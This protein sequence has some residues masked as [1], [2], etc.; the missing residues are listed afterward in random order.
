MNCSQIQE[1]LSAFLDNELLAQTRQQVAGH[2]ETCSDCSGELAGFESLSAM[3]HRLPPHP[4]QK[5]VGDK[6]K[7]RLTTKRPSFRSTIAND[8]HC[9]AV[10]S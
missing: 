9:P 1:L 8:G 5:T 3:A 7:N 2:L 4:C 6:L 10:S